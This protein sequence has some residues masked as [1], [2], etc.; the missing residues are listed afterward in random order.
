MIFK[1]ISL[2]LLLLE[3]SWEVWRLRARRLALQ[4][5]LGSPEE[6]QRRL[7]MILEGFSLEMI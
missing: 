7:R 1:M 2:L 3:R 4:W 6:L 5:H